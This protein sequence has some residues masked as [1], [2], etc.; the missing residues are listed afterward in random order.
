VD[1]EVLFGAQQRN[2]GDHAALEG[3]FGMLDGEELRQLCDALQ[4]VVSGRQPEA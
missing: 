1:V 2:A 4:R 3:W